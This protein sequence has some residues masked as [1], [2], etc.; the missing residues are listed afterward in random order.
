MTKK[1]HHKVS[2][3][4]KYVLQIKKICKKNLQI[5][6]FTEGVLGCVFGIL[7]A[8]LGLGLFFTYFNLNIVNQP[9]SGINWITV[10]GYPKLNDYVYFYS[11]IITLLLGGFFGISGVILWKIKK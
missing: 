3:L 4:N 2:K 9:S 11:F 6:S 5:I 10:S 7:T 1:F 8:I